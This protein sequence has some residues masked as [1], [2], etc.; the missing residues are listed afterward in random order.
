MRA[1]AHIR[2]LREGLTFYKNLQI[3]HG[4]CRMISLR[5][6]S[7]SLLLVVVLAIPLIVADV[8]LVTGDSDSSSTYEHTMVQ[9]W[10]DSASVAMTVDVSS[11]NYTL[12]H[13]PSEV[14]IFDSSLENVTDV[15][16]RASTFAYTTSLSYEF[17]DTSVEEARAIADAIT[18]SMS[19]A[20]GVSFT[21]ERSYVSGTTDA[22]VSYTAPYLDVTSFAELLVSTCVAEDMNGLSDVIPGFVAKMSVAAPY[23]EIGV[24]A[25]KMG[26]GFNWDTSVGALST[27]YS[28]PTGSNSHTI[29]VLDLLGVSSLAPSPY[30]FDGSHYES[31]IELGVFSSDSTSFVSCE[32]PLAA[33]SGEKGW[34]VQTIPSS[35]LLNMSLLTGV[36]GFG[37]DPSPVTE[38]SLTFS[39]TVIPEFTSLTLLLT[40]MLTVA[41]IL[42]LRKRLL[43]KK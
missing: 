25:S 15:G 11:Y 36:F 5:G 42:I 21:F 28:V 33:A 35:P 30:T 14:D 43:Q 4:Y 41:G 20:F 32:P 10:C 37:S 12:V 29:D 38:L 17:D 8:P 31:Q 6:L 13:F 39:G 26:G 18:P 22:V 23:V 9:V 3:Y 1:Q 24:R 2:P 40:L 19:E 27:N 34:T 7:V 16:V